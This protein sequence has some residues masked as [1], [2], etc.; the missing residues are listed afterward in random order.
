MLMARR[1]KRTGKSVVWAM[2][3]LVETQA[4]RTQ[5]EKVPMPAWQSIRFL[6]LI[7]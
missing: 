4:A 3:G 2:P 5:T 1:Y 6:W 7:L